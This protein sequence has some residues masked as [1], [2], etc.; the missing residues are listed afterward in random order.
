MLKLSNRSKSFLFSTTILF[1][2]G[3][4]PLLAGF[5][6]SFEEAVG[7]HYAQKTG[8]GSPFTE[9]A[10][11]LSKGKSTFIKGFVPGDGDCALHSLQVLFPKKIINRRTFYEG[12]VQAFS[13]GDPGLRAAI[14]KELQQEIAQE[15]LEPIALG[16]ERAEGS[17]RALTTKA[18]ELEAGAM[19][20]IQT[21]VAPQWR[22]H[23]LS[24]EEQAL[25]NLIRYPN[26]QVPQDLDYSKLQQIYNEFYAKHWWLPKDEAQCPRPD[27]KFWTT[28]G[29]TAGQKDIKQSTVSMLADTMRVQL[30][31]KVRADRGEETLTGYLKSEEEALRDDAFML[32]ILPKLASNDLFLTATSDG[33]DEAAAWEDGQAFVAA[34]RGTLGLACQLFQLNVQV[35]SQQGQANKGVYTQRNSFKFG[36]ITPTKMMILPGGGGNDL[37]GH[38]SPLAALDDSETQKEMHYKLTAMM[39]LGQGAFK[40]EGPDANIDEILPDLDLERLEKHMHW[41]VLQNAGTMEW[42]DYRYKVDPRVLED[43]KRALAEQAELDALQLPK[44]KGAAPVD[45]ALLDVGVPQLYA[46][47]DLEAAI[48]ESQA[49]WNPHPAPQQDY[50]EEDMDAILSES[51]RFEK[52]RQAN[53]ALKAGVPAQQHPAPLPSASHNRVDHY[54]RI[55]PYPD[56]QHIP[57]HSKWAHIQSPGDIK[58]ADVGIDTPGRTFIGQD[59]CIELFLHASRFLSKDARAKDLQARVEVLKKFQLPAV[60]AILQQAADTVISR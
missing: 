1:S 17:S 27:N 16:M 14:R 13:Y 24:K 7:A 44:D 39:K 15:L 8:E 4:S 5:G 32:Q 51:V 52:E 49:M 18:I 42:A 53:V 48:R 38:Y 47:D 12:L 41:P 29:R 43:H 40:T 26:R 22:S 20:L 59:Q 37:R 21:F 19:N 23:G 3:T 25:C 57:A 36:G 58:F 2:L 45:P 10:C 11:E 60:K 31:N 9:V 56:A 35:F 6:Y 50:A 34:G 46:E 28:E 30:E 54:N 55:E 33:K